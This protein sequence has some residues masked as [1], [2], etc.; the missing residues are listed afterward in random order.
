MLTPP[1]SPFL[2][3]VPPPGMDPAQYQFYLQQMQMQ[4]QSYAYMQ[5][6]SAW[7]HTQQV[8]R[9]EGMPGSWSGT[10]TPFPASP[11]LSPS[12]WPES[13]PGLRRRRSSRHDG[14]R[15]PRPRRTGSTL[16]EGSSRRD[17]GASA[18]S[19]PAVGPGAEGAPAAA[20]AAAPAGAAAPAPAQEGV[21][22][23][24]AAPVPGAPAAPAGPAQGGDADRPRL[25][26]IGLIV[27][28]ALFTYMFTHGSNKSHVYLVSSIAFALYLVRVGLF[29]RLCSRRAARPNPARDFEA[30]DAA[31]LNRPAPSFTQ[32]PPGRLNDVIATLIAFVLSVFPAWVP[33]PPLPDDMDLDIDLVQGPGEGTTEPGVG[34]GA[35]GVPVALAHPG[36]QGAGQPPLHPAA[37][38][39]QA[40]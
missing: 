13:E 17:A 11:N 29:A 16:D 24:A 15:P 27:K 20:A 9:G 37:P 6:M 7:A 4:M 26:D 10:S 1:V 23:A 36:Q 30:A 5:A 12:T 2:N 22:A 18:P 28:L 32:P 25:F 40:A 8:A 38:Q 39:P 3:P 35:D 21:P 34:L 14:D 33:P 31:V 19:T